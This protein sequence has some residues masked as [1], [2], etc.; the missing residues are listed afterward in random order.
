MSL[1]FLLI[2]LSIFFTLFFLKILLKK[3]LKRTL[4]KKKYIRN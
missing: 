4:V 1:D 2:P 3:D